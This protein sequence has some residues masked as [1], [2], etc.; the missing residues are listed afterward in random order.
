ML[1]YLKI[2]NELLT[3]PEYI[4]VYGEEYVKTADT[5]KNPYK[6]YYYYYQGSYR[7]FTGNAFEQGVTYYEL[8]EASTT[9]I[10]GLW[11]VKMD[12]IGEIAAT[13][14]TTDYAIADGA[15]RNT[16]R[17]S[18]RNIT[19][20]FRLIDSFADKYHTLP[21]N[22]EQSR[23]RLYKLFPYK[24][25]ITVLIK[26]DTNQYHKKITG[27][28]ESV[29]P[30]VFSNKETV[31]VSLICPDP[32]FVIDTEEAIG[33]GWHINY[34]GSA[35]NGCVI[36]FDCGLLDADK[37]FSV[38]MELVGS[39]TKSEMRFNMNSIKEILGE[40]RSIQGSRLIIS[41]ETGNKYVKIYNPLYGDDPYINILSSLGIGPF[42]WPI[43]YTGLNKFSI[44]VDGEEV[45]DTELPNEDI[46]VIVD[47]QDEPSGFDSN[48]VVV[49]YKERYGGI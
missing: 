42:D 30:D 7:V 17:V 3:E 36:N 10:N 45:P 16:N 14:N 12:N 9:P 1:T 25:E 11:L 32:Y 28:V 49:C 18:K 46:Y 48:E 34:N 19:M 26:T 41:S 35:Q 47:D 23:L 43:L 13:I 39:D 20:K 2:E 33:K 31:T 27:Y 22:V 6:T 21:K 38:K 4:P 5:Q 40:G 44:Y 8:I 15:Y 29:E 37:D 24:K